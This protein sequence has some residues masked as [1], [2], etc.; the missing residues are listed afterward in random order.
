MSPEGRK[1]AKKREDKG[2]SAEECDAKG[3]F[4][5]FLN[6]LCEFTSPAAFSETMADAQRPRVKVTAAQFGP[7]RGER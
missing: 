7:G 6:K 3:L 1:R 4:F 2:K 5:F